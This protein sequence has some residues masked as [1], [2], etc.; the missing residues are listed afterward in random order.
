MKKI[1]ITF[2][3]VINTITSF[4]Q[5]DSITN[6]NLQVCD[7]II[8][9]KGDTLSVNIVG[10]DNIK[11]N[12]TNCNS[13]TNVTYGLL[14]SQVHAVRYANNE[15]FFYNNENYQESNDNNFGFYSNEKSVIKSNNK[16]IPS[17]TMIKGKI[18]DRN[19]DILAAKTVLE[20]MNDCSDA[21]RYMK[22]AVS[23]RDIGYLFLGASELALIGVFST[24][25]SNKLIFLGGMLAGDIIGL[26]ILSGYKP[27]A[28]TAINIYNNKHNQKS[29]T[30][31]NFKLQPVNGGFGITLQF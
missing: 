28:R 2:I 16:D 8:L 21:Y 25:G 14:K 1:I 19:G 13:N 6:K 27:N 22:R 3:L 15:N 4:S 31:L 30:S 26:L 9:K 23:Y 17:L 5:T 18:Y 10:I 11:I 12:C 29:K 7:Q 24:N 20:M